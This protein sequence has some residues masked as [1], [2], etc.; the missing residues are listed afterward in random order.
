MDRTVPMTPRPLVLASN[1]IWDLC[2]WEGGCRG[3]AR[4]L[5]SGGVSSRLVQPGCLAVLQH[6][7]V[8]VRVWEGNND[9]NQVIG[10][11]RGYASSKL[12]PTGRPCRL[13]HS[14]QQPEKVQHFLLYCIVSSLAGRASQR[15][16]DQVTGFP[17][18]KGH[19]WEKVLGPLPWPTSP[20]PV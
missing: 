4:P 16:Y 12:I 13:E 9:N 19:T 7:L 20:V 1:R 17:C 3:G 8:P 15:I 5:D 18:T 2:W 6:F 10:F 11:W 14:L